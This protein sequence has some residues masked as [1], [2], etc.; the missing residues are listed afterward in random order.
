MFLPSRIR[1]EYSA[2]FHRQ[3]YD[4]V[5]K[6]N[7]MLTNFNRK[8]LNQKQMLLFTAVKVACRK[9]STTPSSCKVT[10]AFLPQF[11]RKKD[12]PI[13]LLLICLV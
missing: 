1:N 2:K 5:K 7:M 6:V 10:A 4:L 11:L 8:I 9:F 3:F 12:Y 13:L